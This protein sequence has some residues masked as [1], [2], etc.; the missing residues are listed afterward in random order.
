MNITIRCDDDELAITVKR[1]SEARPTVS[2]SH[3]GSVE[4]GQ[5]DGNGKR[6]PGSLGHEVAYYDQGHEPRSDKA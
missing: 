6:P 4:G 2:G 5:E 1:N 3:H